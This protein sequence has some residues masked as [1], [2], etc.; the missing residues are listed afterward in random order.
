M[1]IKVFDAPYSNRFQAPFWYSEDGKG[2]TGNCFFTSEKEGWLNCDW[3]LASDTP[4]SCF[5]TN[6]PRERRILFVT[7]PPEVRDYVR[8][9][10]YIE[11]FGFMV[12]LYDIPDY[13]GKIIISNPC[14]GWTAGLS[15]AMNSLTKALAYTPPEKNKTISLITS[16]KQKTTYHKLRV[17]FLQE[18]QKEFSGVL[19]CYGRDFNPV[20]NKLE[21]IAP[22]KYHIVIENSR[23]P[24]Y[25][26]EKLCDAW[27]G[28]AL[29]I[30]C[31]DPTILEQIPDKNG[32]EIID[33]NDIKGA[34]RKIHEIIDG[35]IYSS[36][37]EAIRA[38]REWALK[39]S[40]RYEL[41]KNIIEN[42][43]DKTPKLKT[44]ELFKIIISTRKT[45]AY[46]LIKKISGTLADKIFLDYCRR[47]GRLWE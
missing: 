16:L 40:N 5:Y 20:G 1:T 27:A 24:N 44:P 34:F 12:S 43:H 33:V 2:N 47:N 41:A 11:Q 19:D 29:P 45:A 36:R 25:W 23:H 7:E 4:H 10:Y 17:K 38:C 18:A 31:G 42:S 30:Y 28:W 21:A 26:T 15:G 9:K 3:L 46:N 14:L 22:Y 8:F 13:S 37:L 35:N 32:I 6:I 39:E